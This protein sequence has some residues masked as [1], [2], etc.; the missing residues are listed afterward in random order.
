M[1]QGSQTRAENLR[2]LRVSRQS[3]SKE[4]AAPILQRT[5]KRDV[6][7]AAGPTNIAADAYKPGPRAQALL[8][9]IEIGQSDLVLAGG[10]YTLAEVRAL[11]GKISRQRVDQLV[12]EGRLFAVPGP[13]NARCFPTLQFRDDRT[14]MEGLKEVQAALPTKNTWAILSFLVHPEPLLS[15]RT[16]IAVLHAG[17]VEAV[18]AAASLMGEPG[19]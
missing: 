5:L 1:A 9:G 2:K 12:N 18:V 13:N 19:A 10:T 6:L 4:L 17:E 3:I 14:L 16:P 7:A 15:G 11:L 8:R